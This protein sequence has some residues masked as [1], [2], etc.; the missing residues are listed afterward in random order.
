MGAVVRRLTHSLGWLRSDLLDVPIE[1]ELAYLEFGA[2]EN[3]IRVVQ[4]R[5]L[6]S[7]P[8]AKRIVS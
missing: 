8:D 7:L 6:A 2:V 4:Q 5:V 3:M 1:V